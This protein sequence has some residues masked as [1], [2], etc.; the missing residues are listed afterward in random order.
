MSH[1]PKLF[2][3][4]F[5]CQATEIC[6]QWETGDAGSSA[7]CAQVLGFAETFQSEALQLKNFP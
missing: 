3:I 1:W 6:L 5:A 7:T 4:T 2:N